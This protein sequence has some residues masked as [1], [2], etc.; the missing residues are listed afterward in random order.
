MTVREWLR[1]L[2]L[3]DFAAVFEENLIDEEALLHLT[4][5]DLAEL[6]LPLGP[7]VKIRS[8]LEKLQSEGWSE[9]AATPAAAAKP[10]APDAAERRNLTVM[11]IDLVGSTAL[12]TRLDPEDMRDVIRAYHDTCTE[13]VTAFS[14]HVAKYMGDGVLAYFG[15][16]LAHE[17]DAAQAVR[18]GLAITDAVS[19][20]SAPDG[21]PL[22][23][24]VGIATGL[25]VVGDLVGEDESQERAVVGETPNLAARLEG[26]AQPGQVVIAEGTRA[27]LGQQFVIEEL[28]ARRL[29]GIEGETPIYSVSGERAL[30]SRFEAISETLLPIVGREHELALIMDRWS[31]ATG[32]EGQGVL[33]VGEAG[34]GKSRILRAVLDELED[35][36]HVRIR[37]QCSPNHVD[38]ALWPVVRQ[39]M[40][41]SQIEPGDD[42]EVRKAKLSA[43]IV[44]GVEGVDDARFVAQLLGLEETDHSEILDPAVQRARTLEA[45]VRQ[46]LSLSQGQPALVVLEDAQWSDPTT[47]ELIERSLAAI[48][49]SRV[50]VLITS[51]S[52]EQPAFGSYPHLSRVPLNRL[53]RDGVEA[54]VRELS[55][56]TSLTQD[57]IDE[58]ITR[59]DGVPLFA[60]EL[61]KTVLETGAAKVPATLHDSL[62]A[63]L[64]RIGDVKEV[65]QVAACIGREFEFELLDAIFDGSDAALREAIN[66]LGDA[67]LVFRKGA[68]S[69][70]RYTFKHALL[71]DAAY[72]SLLKSRR[73]ETHA[74]IADVLENEM[75]NLAESEPEVV[76][77][78]LSRADQPERA[79]PYWETAGRRSVETSA[80]TEALG[81]LAEALDA[82]HELPPGSEREQIELRIYAE[83]A[84]PLI[85]TKGYNGQETVEVFNHV[86]RLVEKLGDNTLMFP[87]LY[88]QWL[89]PI[90][91]GDAEQACRVATRFVALADEESDPA[92]VLMGQR[93]LGLSLFETGQPR[94]GDHALK[95]V[96]ELYRPEEHEGLRFRFGQ[97]PYASAMCFRGV[98]QFALGEFDQARTAVGAGIARAEE[99]NHANTLGYALTLGDMTASWCLDDRRR[100]AEV[101]D[102]T[103]PLCERYGMTLWRGF[104]QVFKGW[105]TAL[106][107]GG[108][109]ALDVIELGL[110]DIESTRTGLHMRQL[111]A[112]KALLLL[113]IGSRDDALESFDASI[114]LAR[115]QHAPGFELRAA[116]SLAESWKSM[117][118]AGR[119]AD[120]LQAACDQ[121]TSGF[122]APV[123]QKASALLRDL[124]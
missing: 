30:E 57:V 105:A 19:G 28:G 16:P 10:A 106:E 87:A 59:T 18:A 33:V 60:E 75:P 9:S 32:G 48:T 82:A 34:I 56:G 94:E 3:E 99:V 37:Y 111:L 112:M 50:M 43:L 84:G 70:A 5:A 79:I 21:N 85:S 54:I 118:E 42:P 41:A 81:H 52:D 119:G 115:E 71:Q 1:G 98:T 44:Q 74:R 116:I 77:F 122:D 40:F 20:L 13:Q 113:A 31:R 51:R 47:L 35:Q 120:I 63:R 58:I 29:K 124:R 22:I 6:G 80:Y 110:G 96:A 89:A 107:G 36:P 45:L 66:R 91:R 109:E 76:A 121:I 123:F 46:L 101:A 26:E 93:M 62:M 15:W 90:I 100:V 53:G 55:P 14:G 117:G 7:K 17:D 23:A 8:A 73:R 39:L 103:L 68:L 38:S 78:H 102:R 12:Q 72:D 25:V 104:T 49:D 86:Q 88:Q 24:R 83:M 92:V 65:A 69:D 61:T 108:T 4:D 11:F 27:L 67:G 64:D 114:A 97:D 2:D 95:A